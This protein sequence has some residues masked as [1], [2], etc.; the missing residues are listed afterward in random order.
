MITPIPPTE[1]LTSSPTTSLHPFLASLDNDS[2]LYIFFTASADPTTSQPWCPDVRAAIPVFNSVFESH[3]SELKV[4]VVEV[5]GRDAWKD[6]DNLYKR[7]WGITAIPTLAKYS[8]VDVDGT[9]IVAVRMLVEN[10]CGD[11]EKLE[12]FIR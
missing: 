8:I 5:G 6:A 10:E 2:P 1:P 11:V 7:E 12:Q 9:S 4:M 3:P